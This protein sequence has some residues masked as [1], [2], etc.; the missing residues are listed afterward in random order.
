[1]GEQ[2]PPVDV[3]IV[4]EQRGFGIPEQTLSLYLIK[5]GIA[6]GEAATIAG[7]FVQDWVTT[8]SIDCI[9]APTSRET[10][11]ENNVTGGAF[12]LELKIVALPNR[13]RVIRSLAW[14]IGFA[15]TPVPDQV[16]VRLVSQ[17]SD[18]PRP[19]FQLDSPFVASKRVI[20]D[21]ASPLSSLFHQFLPV[22]LL[23]GDQLIFRQDRG[24]VGP[25]GNEVSV[26]EE[27]YQLPFRPAGL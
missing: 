11:I 7:G 24:V 5:N 17:E 16:S 15:A 21:A 9:F 12:F 25:I 23:P 26:F 6:K 1:M 4:R 2:A 19:H 8:F 22:T 14:E 18:G 10:K 20:G 3:R 27:I 13:I